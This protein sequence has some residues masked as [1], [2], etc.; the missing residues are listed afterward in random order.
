MEKT[1]VLFVSAYQLKV[2][3]EFGGACV[4]FFS[5]GVPSGADPV[6]AASVSEFMR[7]LLPCCL[8]SPLALTAFPPPLP[9]SCLSPEGRDLRDTF[10]LGLSFLSSPSLCTLFPSAAGGSFSDDSWARH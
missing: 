6:S 10:H 7:A 1:K 4:Q 9:Q 8:P 2:A 5:S 3:S